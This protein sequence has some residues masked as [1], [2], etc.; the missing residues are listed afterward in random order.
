MRTK[1]SR[2]KDPGLLHPLKIP[3]G[4]WKHITMDFITS[5]PDTKLHKCNAVMVIVDRLTKRAHFVATKSTATAQ[6]TA[7]LFRD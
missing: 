7:K 3:E 2:R 4:R 1:T 6:D 5:L